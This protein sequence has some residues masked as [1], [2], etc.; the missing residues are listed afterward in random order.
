MT[1][2]TL[3]LAYLAGLAAHIT[4]DAIWLGALARSTY[5]RHLGTLLASHIRWGAAL[6]FYIVYGVGIIGLAVIPAVAAGS[7]LHALALGGLLGLV[8]YGTY[9]LTNHATIRDWPVVITVLDLAWGIL[10]SALSALAGALAA[11]GI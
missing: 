5:K 2:S 6:A 11:R 4:L 7:H 9:D 3:A 8:A 10:A 1:W